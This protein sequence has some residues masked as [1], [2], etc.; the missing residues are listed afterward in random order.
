MSGGFVVD[1]ESE[2]AKRVGVGRSYGLCHCVIGDVFVVAAG[3]D[4]CG[5]GEDGFG[6][7]I[8]FPEAGRQLD[9]ADRAGLLVV[10]PAGAG[11]IAAH[12]AL[13]GEHLRSF[14]EHAA[15]VELIEIGL[16]FA[17]ELGGVRGDEM[18][19]DGGLEE[20][21]PEEGELGEDLALVGYAAAE[22]MVEGGD[23][24]AGDEEELIA[25]EGVDVADLAA[26]CEGKIA[27][28]GLEKGCGHH[29]DGTT[30]WGWG[31]RG[32]VFYRRGRSLSTVPA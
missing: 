3:V 25:G 22:N 16:E 11:E 13:Y 31:K 21:E 5:G 27:E 6:K 18:V 9:A 8:G 24:V 32:M 26:G 19:R 23:A 20:V 28:I 14:D 17:R 2:G 12:D 4:F 1:V 7:A 10:L 30:S 29:V 15:T